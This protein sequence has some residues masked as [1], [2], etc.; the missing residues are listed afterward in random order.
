[1]PSNKR[2]KL[3][4]LSA[5]PG[6]MEAPPRAPAGKRDGRTGSQLI[7]GVRRTSFVQP[8]RMPRKSTDDLSRAPGRPT[9]AE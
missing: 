6:K 4:S 7:R 2:M 9:E 8:Q 3:T 1:M 5:A